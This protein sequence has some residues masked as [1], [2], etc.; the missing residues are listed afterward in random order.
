MLQ[1]GNEQNI[2]TESGNILVGNG[3]P[4]PPP[5]SPQAPWQNHHVRVPWSRPPPIPREG[6]SVCPGLPPI[7]M[8]P[9]QIRSRGR[10]NLIHYY[11]SYI[12]ILAC[13]ALNFKRCLYVF[14]R[15]Y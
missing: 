13:N 2:M 4:L 8:P 9:P 5:P 10:N 12:A 15:L 1:T 7:N 11:S 3:P 14:V 6:D